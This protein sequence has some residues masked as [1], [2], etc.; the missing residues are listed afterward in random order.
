MRTVLPSRHR[1]TGHQRRVVAAAVGVVAL[2]V[3]APVALGQDEVVP[4]GPAAVLAEHLEAAGIPGG[5]VVTTTSE[6]DVRAYGVGTT[7]DGDPV[8][9]RTAFVIGS[10]T[11]SVTALAV[12][13]QVDA[14]AVDLDAPVTR[15][16]P[17]LR[18]AAGEAVDAIA[19]RHLLEHTSGL[20]DLTGGPVLRS[21]VD[22]SALDAVAELRDARLASAP[23]ETWRYANANYVLAGLVVERAS[24]LAY[25]DYVQQRILD[26]LRMTDTRVLAHPDV[27]PGH[28][29]WFGVP[30]ASGPVQRSGVVAAGYV[31]SSARDLGRYLTMYLRDG[32]AAD[33]TRIVSAEGL[34][35]L[36]APGPVAHLGPWADGEVARY[37]MG[38]MVG[39]PWDEPTVFHPGNSPDSSAMIALFPDRDLAAA[40][41]VPASHELPV[42]GNPSLADRISRSTMH[43]V[44]GE[45]VPTP[46]GRWGLYAVFDLVAALLLGLGAWRLVSAVRVLRRRPVSGGP[47]RRWLRPLPALVTTAL[48][49][50]LPSVLGYGWRAAWTWAPDLTVLVAVLV[51]LAGLVSL[52]RLAGAAR[53][54]RRDGD[55]TRPVEP[56]R[57]PAPAGAGYF[58][59]SDRA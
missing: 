30:V 32:L 16:L 23:G 18:L 22:G 35:V 1:T 47:V 50:V 59:G 2:V 53:S 57:A 8:T 27:A 14:G 39:G 12:L 29:Y 49:V 10:T 15:Y 3:A 56:V 6:G 19:V 51:V 34:R 33:G 52:L 46:A 36:T 25:A 37:A 44:L 58:G 7:G 31:A 17:E 24:G 20:D 26:P 40:T 11:K 21:A 9:A 5:A 45:P 38:W 48:L 4:D 43:A 41:L 42:P 13:Q 55:A 28:R 54:V